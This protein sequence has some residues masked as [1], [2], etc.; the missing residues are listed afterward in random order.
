MEGCW[1]QSE[2]RSRRRPLC[3]EHLRLPSAP[4]SRRRP[5]RSFRPCRLGPSPS[6][7]RWSSKS[8]MGAAGVG[9]AGP[10]ALVIA[11]GEAPI[12]ADIM[13]PIADHTGHMGDLELPGPMG[14]AAATAGIA[15]Q[16]AP[17]IRLGEVR[18]RADITAPIDTDRPDQK[19]PAPFL[20]EALQEAPT[21]RSLV[22]SPSRRRSVV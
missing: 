22:R 18:T 6:R 4:R 5:P 14:T 13:D 9:I 1:S 15:V 20:A 7:R 11:L 2:R 12:R 19:G 16:A 8:P 21:P 17:V 10:A 3:S